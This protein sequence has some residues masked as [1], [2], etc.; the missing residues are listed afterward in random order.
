MTQRPNGVSMTPEVSLEKLLR[1]LLSPDQLRLLLRRLPGGRDLVDKIQPNLAPAAYF[2]AVVEELENAGWLASPTL[3]DA[4]IGERPLR[5]S[6]IEAV[7]RLFEPPLPPLGASLLT[8]LMVSASPDGQTRMRVDKEFQEV[9]RRVQAAEHRDRLRLV[10]VV[11][12]RFEDLGTALMRHRPQVLH[13]STHG[14][15]D[16]TLLFESD[17][18]GGRRIPHNNL[19]ALL[20]A[21]HDDLRLVVLNACNSH[22]LARDL[23]AI[24][25]LAIG[26]SDT[27]RDRDAIAFAVAFYEGLAF[28]RD[29]ESAF[30]YAVSGLDARGAGIPRLFPP[31]D[32]DPDDKRKLRFLAPS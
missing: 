12:A 31:A 21:L 22:V 9:V 18:R 20:R 10:P 13:L 29:V 4:L 32:K 16:G 6:D 11:A 26:M 23:P 15:A 19:T 8:I 3:W 30:D 7:K 5:R 2:A 17:D 24:V 14:E 27:F 25:D 28:A 1:S